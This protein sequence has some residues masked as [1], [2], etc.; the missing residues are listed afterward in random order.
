[1][2]DRMGLQYL[3]RLS[4]PKIIIMFFTTAQYF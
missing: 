3:W 4:S 2:R 1:L